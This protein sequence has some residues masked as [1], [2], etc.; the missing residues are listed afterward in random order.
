MLS[1]NPAG[2]ARKMRAGKPL[3]R[4]CPK[5]LPLVHAQGTSVSKIELRAKVP[6]VLGLTRGQRLV[7]PSLVR[8]Q[9]SSE[10]TAALVENRIRDFFWGDILA[11]SMPDIRR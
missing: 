4:R 6:V 1:R 2:E 9:P 10:L 3:G 5:K 8:C 11:R 7:R